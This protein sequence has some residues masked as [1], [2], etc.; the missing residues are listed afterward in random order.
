MFLQEKTMQTVSTPGSGKTALFFGALFGFCSGILQLLCIFSLAGVGLLLS[1]VL[2]MA[3]LLLAGLFASKRTGKVSTG[4]LAGLWS[5]LISS[6]IVVGILGLLLLVAIHNTAFIDASM[7]AFTNALRSDNLPSSI[8]PQQAVTYMGLGMV[9][10][11][12]IWLA[13]GIGAGAGIGAIGGMIGKTMAPVAQY[14]QQPFTSY[15]AAPTF[16][17]YTVPPTPAPQQPLPTSSQP[18]PYPINSGS[19]AP[20]SRPQLD[21]IPYPP[22]PS[23]YQEPAD[24]SSP[25]E[26]NNPYADP[27]QPPY[28]AQD[29]QS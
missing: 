5:G 20:A 12:I 23:F 8:T 27:Q 3:A 19:S 6:V 10:L 13:L 25:A 29:Q 22:P 18:L 14:P 21:D 15:P 28:L 16:P 4:T 24:Q 7:S 17:Q 11:S 26:V 9:I 1:I 2:C